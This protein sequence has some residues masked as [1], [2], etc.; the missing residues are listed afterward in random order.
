MNLPPISNCYI[1]D[2]Q[3]RS[4]FSCLKGLLSRKVPIKPLPLKTKLPVVL[5]E[6]TAMMTHGEGLDALTHVN[7]YFQRVLNSS[8]FTNRYLLASFAKRMPYSVVKIRKLLTLIN[9]ISPVDQSKVIEFSA[10]R[11]RWTDLKIISDLD[12][13]GAQQM[14]EVTRKYAKLLADPEFLLKYIELS[15]DNEED[16]QYP[17]ITAPELVS[18]V[19]S[20]PKKPCQL[21]FPLKLNDNST[22][23]ELPGMVNTTES[24]LSRLLK[25][26]R[27]H[28]LV[29]SRLFNLTDHMIDSMK[30]N[31]LISLDLGQSYLNDEQINS[32]FEGSPNLKTVKYVIRSP[33]ALTA[34]EHL[35]NLT[36]LTL[37]HKK[38]DYNARE[39]DTLSTLMTRL[40]RVTIFGNIP[41]NDQLNTT[42]IHSKF[43]NLTY[44]K[45]T[46]LPLDDDG[47]LPL[48][49][50]SPNIEELALPATKIANISLERI[51]TH[52]KK[53]K[54]INLYNCAN[55]TDLGIINL[56]EKHPSLT[57]IFVG[58]TL[59]SSD[60]PKIKKF[61]EQVALYD[62][63]IVATWEP[64]FKI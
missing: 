5:L 62:R 48:I 46:N 42:F 44:L 26:S 28:S 3:D 17:D 4:F 39:M 52:L 63:K 15:H 13:Q 11:M 24:A 34:L 14:V 56:A 6:E 43:T 7:K 29:F 25:S 37:C 35:K 59:E 47:A 55:L 38:A 51:N 9:K 60:Q 33:T 1:E 22:S 31:Q 30:G 16:Y 8:Q 40:T 23:D 53:L 21:H 61:M 58:S 64:K 54:V 32:L 27:F 45:L 50:S 20:L 49:I 57:K 2:P 12:K 10:L 41:T 19:E 18:L 36:D